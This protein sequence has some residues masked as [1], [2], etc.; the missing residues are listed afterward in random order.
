MPGSGTWAALAV[1]LVSGDWDDEARE[2]AQ[3]GVER[4]R[5]GMPPT[6]EIDASLATRTP[7]KGATCSTPFAGIL[8]ASTERHDRDLIIVR[9]PGSPGGA[10][11][12]GSIIRG[13]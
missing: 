1:G 13:W 6:S 4:E 9:G 5:A 3:K 10:C 2:L 8:S 11:D 12:L 7:I